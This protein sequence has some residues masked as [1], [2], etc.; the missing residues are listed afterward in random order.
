MESARTQ[1]PL[2][3]RPFLLAALANLVLSIAGSLFLHLPGFFRDLGAA[4]AEIGRIMATAAFVATFVGPPLGRLMD[5]R[6]RRVVIL[7]GAVL[8]LVAVALYFTV[9]RI[10][11]W[12]YALRA[13]EGLAGTMLY[14]SL[15]TLGADQVPAE[16]RTEGLA[17]F[18]ASGLLPIAF[19]SSL[20]DF[21]LAHGDYQTLFRAALAL[22]A[23]GLA[24]CLPLRDLRAPRAEAAGGSS[25]RGMFAVAREPGLLPVWIAALAFFFAAAGVST[26]F[27]TFVLE[28]GL[29]T[30]GGF[31]SAYAVIAVSLRLFAGWLPDRIG[32]TRMIAPAF[33]F[34]VAGLAV[35]AMATSSA[36]VLAAGL[37]CGI[38]HG[39][40][41]PVLFSLVVSRSHPDERGAAIAAY[42]AI[43][44]GAH[45]AA[46]PVLGPLIE[47]AGYS[48]TYAVAAAT[49]CVGGVLFHAVD[50]RARAAGAIAAW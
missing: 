43:D 38:G 41:Y 34:Y 28:T 23:V 35:L 39:Y 47:G 29:G 1:S 40:I 42:I 9:D 19:G 45:A 4:E 10:S 12:L 50:R 15:F 8:Y 32:P 36:H 25:A 22:G 20:G 2:F 44:A 27:K 11:P 3:T 30:V 17:I 16:R 37:L 6:G 13:L 18:G 5:A 49:L 46:G 26:F 21:L 7:G 48:A 33:A 24:L 14:A 31:F